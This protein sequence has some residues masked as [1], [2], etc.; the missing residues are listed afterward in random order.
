MIAR[1][2]HLSLLIGV[3]AIILQF[4]ALYLKIY[5]HSPAGQP[6]AIVA[7]IMLTIGLTLYAKSIGRN[8]AWG[9][10]GLLSIFGLLILASLKDYAPNSD[11]KMT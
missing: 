2:N 1:Y 11:E 10:V 8:P 6:I 3:P 7:T 4:L 5:K 9:L